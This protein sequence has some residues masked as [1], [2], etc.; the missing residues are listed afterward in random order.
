[1]TVSDCFHN[2]LRIVRMSI[3]LCYHMTR[4]GGQKH[5]ARSV[6]AVLEMVVRV[7]HL[8]VEMITVGDEYLSCYGVLDDSLAA[9]P[10]LLT[11]NI[12]E[13]PEVIEAGVEAVAARYVI[14]AQTA[15]V[16]G[17]PQALRGGGERGAVTV[18]R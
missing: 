17:S 13:T 7:S 18:T 6:A 12:G 8:G 2:D 14:A 16:T 9:S 4:A 5:E 15:S 11:S 1:M 3:A 10:L